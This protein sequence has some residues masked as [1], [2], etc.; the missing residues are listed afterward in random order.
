MDL[1]AFMRV[2]WRFRVL[3]AAGLVLATL[4]A[5]LALGKPTLSGG[6]PGIEYRESEV[7]LSAS[8]LL[9]TQ[10]GFPWGR[11][12]LDDMI[13]VDNGDGTEPVLVPRY[14]DPG[15]YAGLAQL[16]AELAKGDAVQREV[17]KGAPVGARYESEVVKASDATSTMPM[18]YLKGYGPTPQVASAIANRAAEVFRDYLEAEQRENG[19][20]ADKRVE[21]ILTR[22]ASGAELFAPRSLVRP[23][24]MFLLI[25]M[26]FVALAFFMENLRPSARPAV[27]MVRRPAEQQPQQPPARAA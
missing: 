8:T 17:L 23:I 12:I 7:Y 18:I 11:A 16:Y 26:V 15:R 27:K 1:Y 9:V 22:K 13:T 6:K 10:D 4:V 5:V 24:F 2:A 25:M 14:G 3:L 21:V 19:I 20:A